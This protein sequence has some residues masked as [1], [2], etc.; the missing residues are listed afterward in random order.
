MARA[1]E[2]GVEAHAMLS[3]KGPVEAILG[4][5]KDG[6]A[7]LVVMGTH[8]RKGF[9]RALLGSTAEGV[10]RRAHVPVLVF[11]PPAHIA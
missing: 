9:S 10:L 1:G 11:T 5:V 7:D 3:D 4:A 2:G 8:G 6:A